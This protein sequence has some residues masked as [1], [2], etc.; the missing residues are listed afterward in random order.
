MTKLEIEKAVI[1]VFENGAPLPFVNGIDYHTYAP[2]AVPLAYP[3]GLTSINDTNL[4]RNEHPFVHV[5]GG[6]EEKPRGH[7]AVAF[8]VGCR[9]FY[10]NHELCSA[11]SALTGRNFFHN[12]QIN[13]LPHIV[14][15]KHFIPVHGITHEY[16][17]LI[18][19]NGIT[20]VPPDYFGNSVAS[21]SQ[22]GH[23]FVCQS[24]P[25][26]IFDKM[27]HELWRL[28][29]SG[30]D[31]CFFIA[32]YTHKQ[33]LLLPQERFYLANANLLAD[34]NYQ[35]ELSVYRNDISQIDPCFIHLL[36]RGVR[37]IGESTYFHVF[38]VQKPA[39][40]TFVQ[41]TTPNGDRIRPVG[42]VNNG[43]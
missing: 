27:C 19:V 36:F 43:N 4:N 1:K 32:L 8:P 20:H 40:L 18:E 30:I 25:H 21:A 28:S 13:T 24:S 7:A 42:Y 22:S 15:D 17:D 6:Y 16:P 26:G 31:T 38:I 9:V 37:P 11:M 12:L 41:V 5:T 34:A 3:N 35:A 39:N 23:N 33:N 14:Y 10:F 2:G 29:N